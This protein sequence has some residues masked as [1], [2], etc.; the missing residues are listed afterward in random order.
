VSGRWEDGGAAPDGVFKTICRMCHGGCGVEVDVR[1]GRLVGIR[2]DR[3]NPNNRGFLCA[4]GRAS[5]EHLHHPERLA[6]P[7]RRVG[8]R[9]SGRFERMS[10]DEAYGSIADAL[11]DARAARGPESVVFAQGTDRNYQ[12]WLFRFANAFG[13]PNVLGPAHVCFYPRVMASILTLG[14]FTFCDYENTPD[15]VVVWGSNKAVTHGDG[16]IGTRLLA[17]MKRGTRLVVI[18]PRRTMLARRAEHWLQV[19]PGTDVAL[20]LAMI[21]AIIQA[22][23]EDRTF[24]DEHTVGFD[25]LAGHVADYAPEVVEPITGVPA[26]LIRRA[27]IAYAGAT[28]GAIELGTGP[29]QNRNSFH[30]ARAIAIL[31]AITGNLDRPGGDVIW[32]P[33]GIVGRRSFPL[34]EALTAEQGS[35]RLGAERHRILS[36]S[37]WAHA[38]SVWSAVLDK[39]PYAVTAMLVLGSNLLVNYADSARVHD[40]LASLEFLAVAD[41]FM[42]PTA[43]MA[44]VVVPMSGWLERDQIVEH[45]NYVAARRKLAQVGECRSDEDL[46]CALAARLGLGDAFWDDAAQALD[47]KLAPI[48]M[49]YADLLERQY[50]ATRLEYFKYREKG[51]GTRNG[52]VNIVCEALARFGYDG[53]P[54]HRSVQPPDGDRRS[55]LLTSAHSP[56][57]FN[58]EFRNVPSLRAKEPWPILELHPRAAALEQIADGDWVRVSARERSVLLKA[59]VTDRVSPDVVYA[60]A[61]WWY[62][63]LG[64]P[65]SWMTSNINLLTSEEDENEEMGSS[66]FRGM[67][68]HIARAP[69]HEQHD[70][71]GRPET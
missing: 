8:P 59:R 30:T 9:G 46:L 17:A 42:T 61:T 7:L 6:H 67:W 43:R 16:V 57:Y 26:E 55:Y 66:N 41:L 27:A 35:K 34:T 53:L 54:V 69:D 31:A 23:A 70:P 19:R 10:W 62:P 22:G 32:E 49:R 63:E 20:A 21:H 15:I 13:S 44:D 39:A 1:E 68:C 5:L 11:A 51:F 28:S 60:A 36:M 45:A 29:Q 64:F 4:K 47:D 14:A 65:A 12:E 56:F 58:S 3:D 50:L 48:G 38:G 52:K 40:A 25:A 37:G 18:D 71:G 24:V 2:G 33:S